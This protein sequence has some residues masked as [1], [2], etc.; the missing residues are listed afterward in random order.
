MKALLRWIPVACCI[1]AFAGAAPVAFA[2]QGK[3][4]GQAKQAQGQNKNKNKG[5]KAAKGAKGNDDGRGNDEMRFAGMDRDGNGVITRN[6]WSGN[7]T[8]F[9]NHDWD[10]NG[11]L[12]GDEIR[13]GAARPGRGN[14]DARLHQWD[15]NRDGALSRSE[16]RGTTEAFNRLDI[17]HD[18]V[19]SRSEL[20]ASLFLP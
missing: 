5:A 18:G 1:V 20:P 16:W 12:S 11:V 15:I 17:N 3:A 10:R 19:L 8:S 2:D 14:D 13:P 6:E 9:A 7:D 4:K